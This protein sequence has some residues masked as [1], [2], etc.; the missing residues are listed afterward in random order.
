MIADRR[1]FGDDTPVLVEAREL[2]AQ[3]AELYLRSSFQLALE[4]ISEAMALLRASQ[5]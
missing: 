2:R 1:A 4:L 3:A 5:P